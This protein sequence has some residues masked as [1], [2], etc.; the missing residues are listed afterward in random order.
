MERNRMN[1]NRIYYK[2]LISLFDLVLWSLAGHERA[3]I[4][5]WC[6][7]SSLNK[8]LKKIK[9]KRE[10][11]E[12]GYSNGI[13]RTFRINDKYCGAFGA[14]HTWDDG[15]GRNWNST[16]KRRWNLDLIK[17]KRFRNCVE[18]HGQ[19]IHWTNWIC[20]ARNLFYSKLTFQFGAN[21]KDTRT[22]RTYAAPFLS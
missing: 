15:T 13:R 8:E 2:A 16:N 12:K 19:P 17:K 18:R 1:S 9:C 21:G 5:V 14:V 10:F 11:S 6:L 3:P 7:H 20:C 22:R 4:C